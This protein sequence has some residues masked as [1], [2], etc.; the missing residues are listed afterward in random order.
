MFTGIIQRKVKVLSLKRD[1]ENLLSSIARPKGW[2]LALGQSIAIDGVCSTVVRFN[3]KSFDVCWMPETVQKTTVG[4][5]EKGSMVNLEHS[6]TL[7]DFVDGHIVQGHVD[8][9]GVIKEIEREG[10]AGVRFF[11]QVPLDLV[12]FIA[13]KGSIAM[14]GVS[15]TVVDVKKD[16][17]EVALIPYTLEH[18]N[19]GEL[20]SGD[21][22]NIEV[23]MI[24]RYVA[25]GARSYAKVIRNAKK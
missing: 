10:V 18:T 4:G 11:V 21:E 2:K 24:A 3:A 7:K 25:A 14:N 8:A 20:S 1:K 5:L 17:F 23:D 9:R 6:L 16:I 15:L 19:L 22:V 12:R 13:Q